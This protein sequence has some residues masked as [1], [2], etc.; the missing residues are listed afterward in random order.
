M[1]T[2]YLALAILA[3][4]AYLSCASKPK[5]ESEEEKTMYALGLAIANQS[6]LKGLFTETEL[7]MCRRGMVDGVTGEEP[8][9]QLQEYFPKIQQLIQE[10]KADSTKV[11]QGEVEENTLYAIG[12]AISSQL[13][14]GLVSEEE[15]GLIY[16]G[17][18]DDITGKELIVQLEE[19]GPKI[20]QLMTERMTKRS[21]GTKEE[22]RA[23]LEKAAAEAGAV[24]TASGLVYQE[25]KA[26][27]GP[28]PKT[29]DQVTV[30]Y[31]GTLIDGTVFDSSVERGEPVPFPLNQV[32]P[33]WIEGLQLMKEGGKARLVI[34][35]DLAYG[36]GGQPPTIPGG[37]TLIFEVELLKVN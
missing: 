35:S 9:V 8:A 23:Y 13:G 18:V 20:Q 28:Q 14:G 2:F 36:D 30:H 15:M 11:G 33:G 19:Y 1:K 26:G 7:E 21:E 12:L 27:T 29:T 10:R 24:Q 3:T 25:L 5:V 6:G 32:I 34:P 37:A 22:G 4:S 16:M 31:H 17:V